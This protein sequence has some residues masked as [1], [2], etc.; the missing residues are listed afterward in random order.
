MN[1][2]T[3]SD[4][5]SFFAW[6]VWFLGALFYCYEFFLQVSPSVM[7]N[8]LMRD[9]SISALVLSNLVALYFY[10]YA[11]M[12]IPVGV[13]LDRFGV[14]RLLTIASLL[15]A[16]GC[17]LFGSAHAVW[18]AGVG[19]FLIGLGSAFA[20]VSCLHISATWFPHRYFAALVGVMVSIGMLG[21]VAGEG[22][23]A[24][25]VE[26]FHWRPSMLLLGGI[27][28]VLALLIGVI[29]RDKT[30]ENESGAQ[31]AKLQSQF[32]SGI[33]HVLK[34]KQAWVIAVC[35]GLMFAPTPVL[36]S[37]WGVPFLVKVYHISRPMAATLVSLLF[38]G[39]IVGAPFFGWF[40]DRI[41]KRRPPLFISSLGTF[42]V[43][44]LIVHCPHYFNTVS[45]GLLLFLFGIFSSAFLLAFSLMRENNPP[46]IN[47]TSLG[48]MNM[49]N[50]VG[51]AIAEPLVGWILDKIHPMTS[52]PG[53]AA[54]T[55]A[56]AD[57]QFALNLLPSFTLF[58]FFLL[59]WVEETGCQPMVASH[60]AD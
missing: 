36:S 58:A 45:M 49:L 7:V 27:G 50:T 13:L 12:Q 4:R 34:N 21:A 24:L 30:I 5:T 18:V 28:V 47:A 57:Y 2:G 31:C 20:A 15:C 19:R 17:L 59:F 25:M 51:A 42:T 29:V 44:M 54:A 48:F 38:I 9:F 55:Y 6:I 23:M 40:S 11:V 52:V 39:W 10:A 33:A 1:S 3:T 60:L 43:L 32:W 56:L 35:G 8:E 26:T 14:R 46:E 22:P 37:L 41:K 53:H 16:A